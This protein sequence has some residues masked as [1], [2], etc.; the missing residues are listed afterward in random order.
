M[1]DL[2]PRIGRV[3]G[4]APSQGLVTALVVGLGNPGPEYRH[5]RH[6]IGFMVVERLAARWRL[7]WGRPRN[8][9]RCALGWVGDRYVALMEPLTFMNLSGEPVARAVS[10]Y[11]LTPSD[12][13]VI[14]DDLDLPFGKLRLRPSGSAGGH[15]GAQSLIDALGTKD[16]PRLRIGIG[17][18]DDDEVRDF[19]LS[20]FS[21]EEN[22]RLEAVLDRAASAVET[23][24]GQGLE[25]AMNEFNR[26]E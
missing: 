18:P 5:T 11:S 24:L 2:L 9:A 14:H 3:R 15:R 25:A 22:K 13:L 12:L 21:P 10:Q 19:V 20:T 1:R 23:V 7:R 4:P 6:N 17:R 26:L 16:F 8:Q